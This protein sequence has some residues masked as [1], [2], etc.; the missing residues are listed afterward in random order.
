MFYVFCRLKTSAFHFCDF[1][2]FVFVFF[3]DFGSRVLIVLVII[4][5]IIIPLKILLVDHCL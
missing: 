1:F 2:V 3:V 5:K 4:F